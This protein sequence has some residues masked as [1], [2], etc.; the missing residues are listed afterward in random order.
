MSSSDNEYSEK[1]YKES[2]QHKELAP[3]V[4]LAT[5]KLHT[6]DHQSQTNPPKYLDW[7]HGE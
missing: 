6:Y 5:N 4:I 3:G 7:R 1:E 2:V